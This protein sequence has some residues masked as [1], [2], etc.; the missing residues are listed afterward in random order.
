M[1]Y[2]LRFTTGEREVP[3]QVSSLASRATHPFT[4]LMNWFN[5]IALVIV[6][7]LLVWLQATFSDCV[8]WS[9]PS[10]SAAQP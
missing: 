8:T 1:I 6:A 9:A 7:Y 10:R 5:T 4:R 2:D 3:D